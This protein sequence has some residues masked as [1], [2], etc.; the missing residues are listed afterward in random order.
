MHATFCKVTVPLRN[1]D[2]HTYVHGEETRDS[3]V[4]ITQTV[5]V[6]VTQFEGSKTPDQFI[7]TLG[8]SCTGINILTGPLT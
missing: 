3:S 7:Y 2:I 8:Q 4:W 6:S 5:L 1:A